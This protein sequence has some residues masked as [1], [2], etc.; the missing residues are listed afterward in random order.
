M[1]LPLS[2]SKVLATIEPGG[3]QCSIDV[4]G[5]VE[6]PSSI[7][8]HMTRIVA[9]APARPE[10]SAVPS[11]GLKLKCT[12]QVIKFAGVDLNEKK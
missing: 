5:V 2:I 10:V 7:P 8:S 6:P 4:R 12:P 1:L 11:M 9:T 3:K